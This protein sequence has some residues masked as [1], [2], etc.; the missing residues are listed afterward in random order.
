MIMVHHRL[1][2]IVAL[3]LT[4]ACGG[5]EA[6]G[7][8]SS[9]SG[10]TTPTG[11]GGTGGTSDTG[12]APGTGGSSSSVGGAGGA[13]AAGGAGVVVYFSAD[14]GTETGSSDAAVRDSGGDGWAAAELGM[15]NG[16]A[17]AAEVR[18]TSDDG[19]AF[20]TT[21]YLRYSPNFDAN[22]VGAGFLVLNGNG[23][24]SG[25]GTAHPAIP[26]LEVGESLAYRWYERRPWPYAVD[27]GEVGTHGDEWPDQEPANLAAEYDPGSNGFNLSIYGLTAGNGPDGPLDAHSAFALLGPF[28]P[29]PPFCNFP[30]TRGTVY[31]Y[32]LKIT[33]VETT[34]ITYEIRISDAANTLLFD[35]TDYLPSSIPY[36]GTLADLTFDAPQSVFDLSLRRF[37]IGVNG[38]NGLTTANDEQPGVEYAAFA[39]CSDWCGAYPVPGAEG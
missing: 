8:P 39:M 14:W 6:S 19:V 26:V 16:G 24:A 1:I 34:R 4:A 36:N 10:A 25:S 5:D 30:L 33:R 20:P 17:V 37:R 21:N 12:G 3:L 13:G 18:V 7:D 11:G 23:A 27:P 32:E 9:S 2:V 31:R 15:A 28:V 29:C 22:A 35:T 38:V